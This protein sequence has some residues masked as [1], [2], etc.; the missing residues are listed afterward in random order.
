M[1]NIMKNPLLKRL[2]LRVTLPVVSMLLATAHGYSSDYSQES[3]ASAELS[4][5][6]K[7]RLSILSMVGDYEVSFDFEETVVLDPNYQKHAPH[8]SKAREFVTLVKDEG[9]LIVLQHILVSKGRMV[10]KHWRQDWHYQPKSIMAFTGNRTWEREDVPQDNISGLWAQVV[11][12]VDDSPRYTALGRWTHA[13]NLSFWDSSVG[14]RPLPRREHSTRKDY[15]Q[16]FSSHRLTILDNSWIH[17]QDTTKA[18]SEEK[19]SHF[20]VREQGLNT[21]SRLQN[22]NLQAGYDYWEAT[23]PFWQDVREAWD[24]VFEH[25]DQVKLRP[26]VNEIPLWIHMFWIAKEVNLLEQPYDSSEYRPRIAKIFNDFLEEGSS[27]FSQ[28]LQP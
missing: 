10:I 6:E 13:D 8:H 15:D 5:F 4:Q 24:L 3:T 2:T 25:S 16:M 9:D 27:D 11:Y 22:A 12:Q 1:S 19:G 17:E 20:L 26:Q 23:Q 21:Y 18:I 28:W 7:D 14:Q